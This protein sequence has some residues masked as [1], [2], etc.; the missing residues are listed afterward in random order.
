MIVFRILF[1]VIVARN[2]FMP[3]SL[4]K[5]VHMHGHLLVWYNCTAVHSQKLPIIY[6]RG[7]VL[8][9]GNIQT[10]R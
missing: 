9:I 6:E 2:L 1:H 8:P 3:L 5:P 4:G 7:L 10:Y